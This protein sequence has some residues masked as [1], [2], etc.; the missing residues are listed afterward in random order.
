MK[1]IKTKI[2]LVFTIFMIFVVVGGVVLNSIFLESY[3][4]YRNKA[5]FISLSEKISSEYVEDKENSYEYMNNINN[6]ENISTT[7]VDQNLNIEYNSVG[8]KK[9]NNEKRL[10]KEIKQAI[11]ENEKK[12]SNKF[13]YYTE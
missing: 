2:F 4:V 11:L 3:Y 9:D 1:T 12:L 5:I 6:I 10:T 8:V 7:V 13:V